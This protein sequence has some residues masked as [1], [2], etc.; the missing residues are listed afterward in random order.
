MAAL[1]AGRLKHPVEVWRYADIAKPN[2][3]PGYDRIW[4]LLRTVPAEVI[5]QSGREAVIDRSLTGITVYRLTIRWTA[6]ISAEDQL[7][8][9]PY[10]GGRAL[11]IRSMEADDTGRVW[12]SILADTQAQKMA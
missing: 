1:A 10:L 11:A 9:P 6:D 7:R 12:W 5:G 2:G 8:L 4:S 3:R